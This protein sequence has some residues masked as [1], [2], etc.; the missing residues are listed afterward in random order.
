MD[1]ERLRQLLDAVARG[2]LRA[3][4]AARQ[5]AAATGGAAPIPDAVLDLARE[6]RT[7]VPEVVL[8]EWKTADQ[9]AAILRGLA[10]GGRGALA[11]RID[12]AKADAVRAQVPEAEHLAAA[13]ALVIRPPAPRPAVGVVAIVCAG[14][15]DLPVAE[16]AAVT[17]EFLG[18]AVRR[19]TDVGVAGLHRLLGRM[20]EIRTADAIVVIA[21]MEGA[22]PSVVAG[23][24]DRPLVAVP[25]SVG[26]GVGAGGLVAMATMLSSCAPGVTVVNIDNGFGA[27]V[28]AVRAARPRSAA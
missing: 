10:S 28:A 13:R 24:C 20:S 16:E 11:T 18:A 15:S 1:P 8:G 14:T 17:A 3:D 7:G 25:T 9:V 22:L 5:I 26:Y 12:A 23:L 19:V 4:E 6:A 2:D 21:G 27:A